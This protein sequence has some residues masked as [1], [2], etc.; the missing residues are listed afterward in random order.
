MAS[1]FSAARPKRSSEAFARKHHGDDDDSS[2]NKKIK[3]DLRNP[4]A[5]APD[6]DEDDYDE[7]DEQMLAADVIRSTQGATKRGAVNIDGY[8]SDS[9]NENFS[10]RAE[11]RERSGGRSG[12][13][14]KKA[15]DV[16]LAEQL[17]NYDAKLAAGGT[18]ANDLEDGDEEEELDIFGPDDDEA[19]EQADEEAAGRGKAGKKGKEVR[20]LQ[21]IAG[22]DLSSTSREKIDFDQAQE[23]SSDDEEG[24]ELEIQEEGIDEEVGLGG[25]K[26]HAP[27]IDAFNMKQEQEEGAFDEAGNYIRKAVDPD[28]VH[29]K[30]LEGVSKKDMKKAAAAHQKRE[31]ELRQLRREEDKV[32]TSDLFKALIPYLEKSE[33]PLEALARLG[34]SKTEQKIPKWKQKRRKSGRDQMIVDIRKP[35]DSRQAEIKAAIDVITDAADGLLKRDYP[36]IYDT[37]RELM[38]REYRQET[39]ED[40]VD[41]PREQESGLEAGPT[42]TMWEYRWTDGRGDGGKQGPFDVATMRAW[43]DAGYFDEGVEFKPVGQ[44]GGWT[45][46]AK[47]V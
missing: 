24:R 9:E 38:I 46:I 12:K 32:L 6:A 20:F 35:E 8:D 21:N 33:T 14:K 18:A 30:W 36:D 13:G 19:Q 28:A 25:L 23:S 10:A 47:F 31:A 11:A 7:V 39:G 45:R 15:E 16:N 2:S 17:D 22:Q 41:P 3:F 29:D 4:S 5:L 37:E 42:P 40:W 34:R 26:K 27:K 44:E 43:Q 1:R